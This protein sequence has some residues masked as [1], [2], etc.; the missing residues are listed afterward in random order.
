MG[1]GS[2]KNLFEDN[3]GNEARG[4]LQPLSVEAV[5]DTGTLGQGVGS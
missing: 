1:A 3:E 4:E 2:L 5:L